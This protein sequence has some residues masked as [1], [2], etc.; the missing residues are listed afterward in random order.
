FSQISTSKRSRAS[1]TYQNPPSSP[2]AAPHAFYY[3]L[4]LDRPRP[5]EALVFPSNFQSKPGLA[6]QL[7]WK[8]EEVSELRVPSNNIFL[9]ALN[10]KLNQYILGCN[11]N[12][13]ARVKLEPASKKYK[14]G[15]PK[16]IKPICTASSHPAS[17]DSNNFL[18]YS[19]SQST[20][21]PIL[22]EP[23][24]IP[25]TTNSAPLIS[26][27]TGHQF[28]FIFSANPDTPSG[29][30]A[31]KNHKCEICSRLFFRRQDL[32]RHKDTH[33]NVRPYVCK[34]CGAAFTRRD[35]QNRHTKRLTCG[36]RPGAS[37]S[38][39]SANT[40]N[41]Q[42]PDKP[43][44]ISPTVSVTPKSEDLP[45]LAQLPQTPEGL[46]LS[47]TNTPETLSTPQTP[48]EPIVEQVMQLKD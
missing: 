39:K 9:E 47:L 15:R 48:V 12:T 37:P 38:T 35:A 45:I 8:P 20:S 21:T 3:R 32:N 16:S 6:S 4:P 19:P 27:A 26:N 23:Q 34:E 17:G 5:L 10:Y 1:L 36:A 41:E 30:T 42:E 31:K 7:E 13:E 44:P 43:V 22:P 11:K 18:F 46:A 2:I 28:Q 29:G 33:F 14:G 24:A 40:P 25:S